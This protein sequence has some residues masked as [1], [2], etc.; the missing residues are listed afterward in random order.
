MESK[1][2]IWENQH[3]FAKGKFCLTNLVAFYDSL[4][5]SM[6]K[7]RATGVILSGPQ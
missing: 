4:T 6:D 5:A 2:V 3:G 1:E 7:G